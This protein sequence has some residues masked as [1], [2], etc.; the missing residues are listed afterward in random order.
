[1]LTSANLS[2]KL[3]EKILIMVVKRK[4]DTSVVSRSKK[5]EGSSPPPA[6]NAQDIFRK[7]FEAQFEPIEATPVK[8]SEVSESEED[9][10]DYNSEDL[11]GESDSEEGWDGLSEEEEDDEPKVEVV[12]HKDASAD[13]DELMQKQA[14][15]AFLV[16]N[17]SPLNFSDYKLTCKFPERY[18]FLRCT[19][20]VDI[21]TQH[22]KR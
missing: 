18:S 4:R 13:G 3:L 9:D 7:Y 6:D 2:T 12:E 19:S 10:E 1:M 17:F 22:R 5:A 11:D 8:A 21:E 14:R 20:K 15:K 16:R